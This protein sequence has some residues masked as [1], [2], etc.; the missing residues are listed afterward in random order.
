MKL[1]MFAAILTIC[2]PVVLTSCSK[3]ESIVAPV[4]KDYFT[5]WNTCESLTALQDRKKSPSWLL[6]KRTISHYGIHVNR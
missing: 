5:L 2:G 6:S 4:Q 3:E 1:W